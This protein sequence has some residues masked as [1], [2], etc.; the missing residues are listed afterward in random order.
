MFLSLLLYL[1]DRFVFFK[2]TAFPAWLRERVEIFSIY[3]ELKQIGKDEYTF[4]DYYG[5]VNDIDSSITFWEDYN[6]GNRLG[7]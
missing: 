6:D 1:Y 7:I 3:E 5:L 2:V 4:A